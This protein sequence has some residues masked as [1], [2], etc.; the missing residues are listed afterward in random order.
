MIKI[1]VECE[2]CGAIGKTNSIAGLSN[3]CCTSCGSQG[4]LRI[5]SPHDMNFGAGGTRKDKNNGGTQCNPS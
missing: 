4:T 5:Y 3:E 1:T 2:E